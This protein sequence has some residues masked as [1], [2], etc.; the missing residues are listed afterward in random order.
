MNFSIRDLFLVT[1]IVALAVGW[2]IDRSKL[3]DE[4]RNEIAR[5]R[6]EALEWEIH[7]PPNSSASVRNPPNP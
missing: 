5:H 4:F 1:M 6:L 7:P 3:W 2:W